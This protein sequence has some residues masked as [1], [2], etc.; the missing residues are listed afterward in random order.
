V[1]SRKEVVGRRAFGDCI[2]APGGKLPPGRFKLD[3]FYEERE[4]EH[5]SLDRLGLRN[6]DPEVRAYL[7]PVCDAHALSMATSF[8]CWAALRM[9]DL[10]Q[11]KIEPKEEL[12]TNPFHSELDLT[13]YRKKHHAEA[14][15]FKL[16]TLAWREDRLEGESPSEPAAS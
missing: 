3:V 8:T 10:A 14:L 9:A 2:T 7:T 5:L 1:V 13:E 6:A 12:P 15:A 4:T 16:S 11:Q